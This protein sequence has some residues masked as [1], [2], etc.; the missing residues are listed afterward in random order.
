MLGRGIPSITQLEVSL[1]D[2]IIRNQ[3]IKKLETT[4]FGLTLSSG[5]I[6]KNCSVRVN[7]NARLHNCITLLQNSFSR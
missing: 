7:T 6:L 2:V 5:F 3:D 1:I 4:C